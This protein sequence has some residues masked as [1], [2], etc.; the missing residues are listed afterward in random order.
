MFIIYMRIDRYMNKNA[1]AC[2]DQE[3]ASEPLELEL[4]ALMS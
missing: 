1:G 4:Q 3:S 2:G